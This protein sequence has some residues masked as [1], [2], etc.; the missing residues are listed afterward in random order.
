MSDGQL[1]DY[2]SVLA[3]SGAK[4]VPLRA[5]DLAGGQIS[6]PVHSLIDREKALAAN[7]IVLIAYDP[8][9]TNAT[10]L[11][12]Y[13][14]WVAREFAP[15]GLVLDSDSAVVTLYMRPDFPCALLT[16][17]QPLGAQF[18]NGARLGNLVAERR[19]ASLDVYFLWEN[20]PA[21]KHSVSIQF[22][23]GA[24][25]K[26]HNQ[27]FVLA[28]ESLARRRIALGPL[29]PGDYQVKMIL[30]GYATGLSV[31]GEIVG[32]GARFDRALYIGDVAVE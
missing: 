12:P 18:D 27:D 24:G 8:R 30:Y 4:P 15:C 31:S 17:A 23:D 3:E 9:F 13:E 21:E 6:S 10:I 20:R 32:S 14:D 1:L 2:Y 29:A 5:E 16:G 7:D 26:I 11:A 25:V 19:G 28:D 22:F